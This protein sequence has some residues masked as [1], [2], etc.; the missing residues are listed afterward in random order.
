[1]PKQKHLDID[2]AYF[3]TS[4][5]HVLLKVSENMIADESLDLSRS[6]PE[7]GTSDIHPHN[8]WLQNIW[9]E[10]VKVRVDVR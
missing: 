10:R 8:L 1:M 5:A 2:G 9:L 4:F 3:G 7:G 6:V